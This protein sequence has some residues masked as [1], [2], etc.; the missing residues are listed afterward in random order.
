M[1]HVPKSY[2]KGDQIQLN[3][4]FKKED[5]TLGDPTTVVVKIIDP[6]GNQTEFTPERDDLGQYHYDLDTDLT[7]LDGYWEYRF[8]GTGAV[9]SAGEHQFYIRKTQFV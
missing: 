5:G 9:T 3:A 1:P 6:A 7:F 2:D 4:V 8:E